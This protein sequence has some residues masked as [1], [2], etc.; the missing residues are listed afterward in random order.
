MICLAGC[1]NR[2]AIPED[3]DSMLYINLEMLMEDTEIVADFKT[4]NNLNGTFPIYSPE[5]AV[6]KISQLNSGDIDT[7]KEVF[8]EYDADSGKYVSDEEIN[9]QF[10]SHGRG[11]LLEASVEGAE[12]DKITATTIVPYPIVIDTV[13]L[14]SE[15][16]VTFEENDYWQGTV[17]FTFVSSVNRDTRYGQ[18]E[19]EGRKTTLNGNGEH[20][21]ENDFRFFELRDINVGSSAVTNIGHRDG[22][23]ID[24][25]NLENDYIEVV[26]RS[27]FP[28]TDPN[29]VTDYLNTNLI[30]VSQEHYDYHIAIH[31]IKKNEGNIFEENVLYRSNIEKGLG[32]FSSCYELPDMH[33]LR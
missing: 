14:L 17:G 26:L 31:N 16:V 30:A 2:I 3:E 28:I 33:E 11:Y 6:I 23:L 9:K 19:I 20:I 27:P 25:D 22:Y 8:L 18:L 32:L 12:F 4:T 13:V 24:F 7:N 10:L 15:E 5:N 1:V 29:Q 21:F